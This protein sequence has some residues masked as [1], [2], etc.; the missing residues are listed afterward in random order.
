VLKTRILA[1]IKYEEDKSNIKD[2][3]TY[4]ETSEFLGDYQE[5][6]FGF[7]KLCDYFKERNKDSFQKARAHYITSKFL[8]NSISVYNGDGYKHSL[9]SIRPMII[10]NRLFF[11][12]IDCDSYLPAYGPH[13]TDEV[14]K[15]NDILL[16]SK[17][18]TKEIEKLFTSDEI[19]FVV[20]RFGVEKLLSIKVERKFITPFDSL[21]KEESVNTVQSAKHSFLSRIINGIKDDP[22]LL[23][24]INKVQK[25]NYAIALINK[26]LDSPLSSEY[27]IQVDQQLGMIG[28]VISLIQ[29]VKPNYAIM[30]GKVFFGSPELK[31]LV[32]NEF[33]KKSQSQF[34]TNADDFARIE[35]N[36][37]ENISVVSN[38]LDALSGEYDW[39]FLRSDNVNGEKGA[40]HPGK[41]IMLAR[42]G[43][44]EG[45][46][47]VL[48]IK[49]NNITSNGGMLMTYPNGKTKLVSTSTGK[50]AGKIATLT[51][52]SEFTESSGIFQNKPNGITV[53]STINF[54]DPA[55]IIMTTE[56]YCPSCSPGYQR[57]SSTS[58][59]FKIR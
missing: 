18:S 7:S 35:K 51:G 24:D 14:V 12:E 20:R 17:L 23:A 32:G 38:N 1:K 5:A 41:K 46:T 47:W 25:I 27:F 59:I 33:L 19:S 36:I 40:A 42:G 37:D 6:I 57:V 10:E 9:I 54:S 2:L 52:G 53:K 8:L 45:L 43:V 15:I 28:S 30:K 49:G 44:H 16:P 29:G 4:A 34:E 55:R 26:W 50:I 13:P 58:R 11:A 21:I 56:S 22:K 39:E 3:W 48:T 31:E